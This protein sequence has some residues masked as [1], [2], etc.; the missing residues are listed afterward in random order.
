MR[1]T[2]LSKAELA[3]LFLALHYR[4]ADGDSF[5]GSLEYELDDNGDFSVQGC[6]R[7][8]N[9]EGQGGMVVLGEE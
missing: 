2:T 9:S 5:G 6:Y 4:I 1:P 7:V 3:D 8:G